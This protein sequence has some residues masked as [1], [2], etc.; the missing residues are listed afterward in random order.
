MPLFDLS[1]DELHRYRP[2]RN[3]PADF[4]EF[5]K[6]S[7]EEAATHPLSPTFSPVGSH[8]S[9]VDVFDVEFA[10]W[11]GDPIR[12]WLITPKSET[13]TGCV[14]HYLGYGSGRGFAHDHLAWP[15]AG[16]ATLVV[17]TRGQGSGSTASPGHT[18]DPHG[19]LG[20]QAPGM[21]TKGILDPHTYYY[22]RVFTDAARAVDVAASHESIDDSRIVVTGGSQGGGIAQAVAAVQPRVAAALI[23][24]P[25]LTHFR[26]AVEISSTGPYPEIVQYLAAQRDHQ[27]RVFETLSYFDGMNFAARGQVPALY[28]TAL[29]DTTCPPSTVFAAYN[30]WAGPKGIDVWPWNK[31]EGGQGAQLENQMAYLAEV[32]G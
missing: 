7:F 26:R 13:P 4:D 25:F 9:L 3:E 31:H 29:M 23:D 27:D 1:L 2:D 19:T 11:N 15:A 32:L 17:D 14:V 24:V 18:G 6:R 28:S 12:A 30:H 5:W 8:L 22:R 20:A 10:G 16:W 21:M